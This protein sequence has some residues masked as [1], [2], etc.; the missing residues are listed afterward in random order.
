MAIIFFFMLSFN[1]AFNLICSS[2]V[3]C[4]DDDVTD[5]VSL[6]SEEELSSITFLCFFIYLFGCTLSED[7]DDD[8]RCLNLFF[9]FYL[10]DEEEDEERICFFTFN[11]LF[12]LLSESEEYC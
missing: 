7:D 2:R 12:G 6:S 10:E 3:I 8:K 4:L 5:P 1:V 11:L 9:L